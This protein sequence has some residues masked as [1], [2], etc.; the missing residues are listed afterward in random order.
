M[1]S[2]YHTPVSSRVFVRLSLEAGRRVLCVRACVRAVTAVAGS[3]LAFEPWRLTPFQRGSRVLS[4]CA[5]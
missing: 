3:T 1:P 2:L 4:F 5:P